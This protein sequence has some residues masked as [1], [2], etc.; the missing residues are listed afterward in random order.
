MPSISTSRFGSVDFLQYLRSSGGS[1]AKRSPHR[2]RRL[3]ARHHCQARGECSRAS[4]PAR[5]APTPASVKVPSGARQDI[6]DAWAGEYPYDPARVRRSPSPA[7]HA[8]AMALKAMAEGGAMRSG[9]AVEAR[10][11][12]S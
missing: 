4:D 3:L 6:F 7:A 12:A 5:R 1:T 11:Q 2:A 10:H 8:T 9:F